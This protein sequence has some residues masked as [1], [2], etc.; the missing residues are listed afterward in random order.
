MKTGATVALAGL[1]VV[2]AAPSHAGGAPLSTPVISSFLAGVDEAICHALNV[3]TKPVSITVDI[4]DSN[5]GTVVATNGP[6]VVDPGKELSLVNL[7]TQSNEYCRAT[8]LSSKTGK[9]SFEELSAGS[10][11]INVTAP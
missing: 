5:L 6:A 10:P 1:L 3:G 11:V 2:V 4:V 8:G 9:M 7:G